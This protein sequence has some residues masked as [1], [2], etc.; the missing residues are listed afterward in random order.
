ML[1]TDRQRISYENPV[2]GFSAAPV[3]ELIRMRVR[4]R[5]QRRALWL[6]NTAASNSALSHLPNGDTPASEEI[7]FERAEESR[8]LNDQI[9]QVEKALAGNAGANLRQLAEMFSLS[10]SE[11]DLLQTCIAFEID[12]S[13]SG[14]FDYLQGSARALPTEGL[15]ARL[16]GYGYQS[17]WSPASPLALWKF[18]FADTSNREGATT[19]SV[20]RVVTDWLQGEL[21][22]DRRLVGVVRTIEQL[23]PLDG[24]PVAATVK[25]IQQQVER[26]FGARVLVIAPPSSG[27]KTFSATVAGKLGIRA[28]AVDTSQIADADWPDIY[29]VAQRLAYLSGASPIWYGSSLQRAWPANIRPAGIQF[30][31]CDVGQTVAPCEHIVDNHVVL[32]GTTVNER[33]GLWHEQC[34][35]SR[36]WSSPEFETILTRYRLNAG[37]IRSVA[38]RAPSSSH[39]AAEFCRETMRHHLDELA[40]SLDC[41]FGWDDLIVS[42][43]VGDAL[44]DFAFEARDRTGFWESSAVR[45]LFPR[46]TGLIALFNG[47]SGT[48]K[49]MAAQ[50][51]AADL[52]LDLVRVDLASVVSKYI[53]ETAK[54]LSQIFAR[55]SRMNVVLLFDEADALFSKRTE[56]KDAHDRYANTD[57]NYLLQLVEEHDG[58]VVLATNKKQN[59]DPAFIRRIRYVI[60]F[61]RPESAERRVI[62]R[63]LIGDLS[64]REVLL[65]LEPTIEA[66][67]VHIELSG[68][69]IKNAVLAGVFAGRRHRE[70]LNMAHLLRGIERELGK[71]GRTLGTRE[72][73]RLV[74]D[75]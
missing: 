30:V 10:R 66:L 38:R 70:P 40:R 21:R 68:A 39:E 63:K 69:Q 73:E 49:T 74:R 48:G 20:D 4:L 7:W 42:E 59:V 44:A 24:W 56:V 26:G 61:P 58:I 23:R 50:V 16:F 9:A 15:A 72:R 18:V 67:A 25:R 64:S 17:M 2:Q 32:P 36:T 54:Y 55:A 37:D 65:R 22:M 57:T 35:E 19:L 31:A 1:S 46:G 60:D 11:I 5:A 6:A 45:R 43:K 34:P 8:A 27:R 51:I 52:Q 13:L 75:V 14:I 62:W 29:V 28:F 3:L 12:P 53:G 33:R 47:P 71:E 41:P